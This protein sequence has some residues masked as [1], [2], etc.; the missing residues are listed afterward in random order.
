MVAHIDNRLLKGRWRFGRLSSVLQVD[1]CR[2]AALRQADAP[3][4][5]SPL[6]LLGQLYLLIH[7]LAHQ[8]YAQLAQLMNCQGNIAMFA[9]EVIGQVKQ[10]GADG[11]DGFVVVG[12]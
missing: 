5:L 6:L 11:A 12:Q 4:G 9:G 1:R 7:G 8:Q 10:Q 2:E 3:I